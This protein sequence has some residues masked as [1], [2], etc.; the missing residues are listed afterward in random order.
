M[1][2][3]IAP[4]SEW[5]GYMAT[6]VLTDLPKAYSAEQNRLLAL[7]SDCLSAYLVMSLRWLHISDF[8][9]F[10]DGCQQ[11]VPEHLDP[12]ADR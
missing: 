10:G 6:Y 3:H 2:R 4:L 1:H 7:M 9:S 8:A 5:C 11:D 12:P